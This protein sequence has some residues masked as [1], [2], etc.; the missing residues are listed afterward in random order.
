MQTF[1]FR[2]A[3][4]QSGSLREAVP[5]AE[6]NWHSPDASTLAAQSRCLSGPGDRTSVWRSTSTIACVQNP[7]CS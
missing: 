7:R 5:F 3:A 4:R 1:P 2:G 6:F